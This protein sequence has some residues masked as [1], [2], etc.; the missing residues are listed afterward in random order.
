MSQ[1]SESHTRSLIRKIFET[2]SEVRYVAVAAGRGVISEQRPGV[3]DASASESDFFEE[4]LVN[5]TILTLL[6]NR[7]E[8]DCGGLRYVVVAYGH[9]FQ[10][11]REL[12]GGHLSVCVDSSGDPI[13]VR[14]VVESVVETWRNSR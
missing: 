5:P 2:C 7:G 3:A 1:S 8:L 11:V 12:E 10:L 6:R 9:F 4:L 13:V 14:S